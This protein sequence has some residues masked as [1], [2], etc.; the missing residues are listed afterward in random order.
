MTELTL[1]GL[2]SFIEST[3]IGGWWRKTLSELDQANGIEPKQSAEPAAELGFGWD[4]LTGPEQDL[5]MDFAWQGTGTYAELEPLLNRLP[6]G[7][8]HD[9]R[10]G[11]RQAIERKRN[12]MEKYRRKLRERAGEARADRPRRLANDRNRC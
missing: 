6:G 12:E 7:M 2:R 3:G 1:N 10:L 4:T 5:V 11:H 8:A 9:M